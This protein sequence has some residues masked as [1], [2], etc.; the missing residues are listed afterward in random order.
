MKKVINASFAV[1]CGFIL[2]SCN[3]KIDYKKAEISSLYPDT[4]EEDD[5]LPLP[6]GLEFIT[7]EPQKEAER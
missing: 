7:E 5:K 6:A 3:K 1:L 2:F 4:V